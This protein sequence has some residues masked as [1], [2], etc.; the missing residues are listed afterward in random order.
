MSP[1]SNAISPESLVAEVELAAE[2]KRLYERLPEE[3]KYLLYLRETVGLCDWRD[4][5]QAMKDAGYQVCSGGF[6]VRYCT[7]KRDIDAKLKFAIAQVQNTQADVDYCINF[8]IFRD[9]RY[10][11]MNKKRF[12]S[13]RDLSDDEEQQIRSLTASLRA[14]GLK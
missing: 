14:T 13:S 11:W 9:R 12:G 6:C 4:V 7:I 1:R 10:S 8:G 5:T 3:D 2:T